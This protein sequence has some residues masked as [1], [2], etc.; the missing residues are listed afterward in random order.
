[1]VANTINVAFLLRTIART[2]RRLAEKIDEVSRLAWRD[3]LTELP[4]RLYFRERLS[5]TLAAADRTQRQV[6]LLLFDIDGFKSVND[7][8]GHEAGDRLLYVIAERVG[9]RIRHADTFARLGGDEFVVLMETI[10]DKSDAAHVAET[11]INTVGAIDLFADRGLRVGVSVGIVCSEPAA[12]RERIA[13]Q[14]LN[15]ADRAM[16]EAKRAGKG[17]YRFAGES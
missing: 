13:D 4:N 1:M 7:T 14:L 6:A 12:A 17:C 9:Q 10:R 3:H 2:N 16:Y 5:Q 8:L 15:Q 11:V